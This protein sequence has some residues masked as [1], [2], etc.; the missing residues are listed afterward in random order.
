MMLLFALGL[1][2]R[3]LRLVVLLIRDILSRKRQE[4]AISGVSTILGGTLNLSKNVMNQAAIILGIVVY[5]TPLVVAFFLIP[6]KISSGIAE[7]LGI[8]YTVV[9][10]TFLL[11]KHQWFDS[12]AELRR[13]TCEALVEKCKNLKHRKDSDELETHK[14]A[15]I[16]NRTEKTIQQTQPVVYNRPNATNFREKPKWILKQQEYTGKDW[17]FDE[18][19]QTWRPEGEDS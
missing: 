9:F 18:A 14:L 16:P 11:R 2:I 6:V 5:A 7:V 19:K 15:T 10:F 3:P 17:V 13:R 4:R 12:F 1:L 8:A